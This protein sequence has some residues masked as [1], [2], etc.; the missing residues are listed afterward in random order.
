M[1]FLCDRCKQKYHVADEK[2]R[3]R[4]VTRFKCKKC[5]HV[6]EL[7]LTGTDG[8]PANALP[9]DGSVDESP[10]SIPPPP[11]AGTRPT[12]TGLPTRSTGSALPSATRPPTSS[13]LPAPARAP[14]GTALPAARPPTS[15]GLPTRTA[16]GPIPTRPATTTGSLPAVGAATRTGA[17]ATLPTRGAGPPAP[18][19]SAAQRPATS[20]GLPAA[21]RPGA[22]RPGTAAGL[23]ASAARSATPAPSSLRSGLAGKSAAEPASRST[24]ASALLNAAETGWYAG[25][26]D[27][28][29]GPLTRSELAIRIEAGDITPDSL[30]WREGLDDWRPLRAVEEL[31]D[32]VHA[33]AQ[34]MSH[35]LLGT[36]GRREAPQPSKVVPIAQGRA[37]KG[38]EAF[39]EDEPTRMTA[40]SE[41]IHT[42][43]QRGLVSPASSSAPLSSSTSSTGPG[44]ISAVPSAPSKPVAATVA[45]ATPEAPV[46]KPAPAATPAPTAASA[47][48]ELGPV[49]APAATTAAEKSI[50]V[51]ATPAVATPAPASNR[52][53]GLPVGV[54]IMMAGVLVAGVAFGLLLR[55]GAT[56][57]TAPTPAAPTEPAHVASATPTPTGRQV[58]TEIQLPA[59][60]AP[61]AVVTPPPTPA[62]VVAAVT[63]PVAAEPGRRTGTA[64]VA[65]ATTATSG[66]R[67]AGPA[68]GA[69]SRSGLSAAQLAALNAQLGTQGGVAQS[70]GPSTTTLRNTPQT[71]DS[72]G[73]LT[74]EQRAGQVIATLR[75]ANVV[76]S[77][78][79]AAQRRNPAHPA[80]SIRLSIDVAPTGRATGIRVSGAQDPDLVNCIQT[81]AR[82][83]PYGAG[84]SVSA[85]V[86]FNLVAGQ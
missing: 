19:A 25:V 83:Q 35:G 11:P 64:P 42:A 67:V 38:E 54:W 60:P 16:T 24:A 45:P 29:V 28:P 50:P 18:P 78:W 65:P 66:A 27:L 61:P 44:R 21:S 41:L 34:K 22:P 8:M 58:G 53:G 57:A 52:P 72:N 5:D 2:V 10:A 13:G 63:P 12:S 1:N 48:Y 40:L 69:T 9:D 62:P 32:V 59:E 14:T 82:A 15:T 26:R 37:T 6:I 39:E 47:K 43:E 31:S 4:A 75:R 46:A 30:V 81:R 71:E 84:G 33:A 3:G 76:D 68:T 74:G 85:E 23:S 36:M 51:V 77:C 79:T 7:R 73:G 80:E 70:T 49:A 55:P 86:A 20:T 17:N 56:P